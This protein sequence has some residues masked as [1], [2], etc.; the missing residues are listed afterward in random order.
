MVRGKNASRRQ[1]VVFFCVSRA[2][3][4]RSPCGG[5]SLTARELSSGVNE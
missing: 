2:V 4:V 1:E 5:A 3:D